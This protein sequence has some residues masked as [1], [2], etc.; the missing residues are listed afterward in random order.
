MRKIQA[1]NRELGTQEINK[2]SLSVFDGKRSVSKD[3]IHTQADF[4]KDLKK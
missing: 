1:Q 3:G 4:P 2:K